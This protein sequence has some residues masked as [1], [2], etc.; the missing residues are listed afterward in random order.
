MVTSL[1]CSQ[2]SIV[3]SGFL[4]PHVVLTQLDA[5][6]HPRIVDDMLDGEP[7]TLLWPQQSLSHVTNGW[8]ND[9][10]VNSTARQGCSRQATCTCNHRRQA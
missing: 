6:L 9:H 7:L 3:V 1:H 8:V 5:L 10:E 2:H 4:V